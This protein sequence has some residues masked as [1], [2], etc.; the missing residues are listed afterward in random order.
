MTE[1]LNND[2]I[3]IP[4]T[5]DYGFKVTF[6]NESNTVFLKRA[7]QAL[8]NSPIPIKSITFDKTIFEGG[9]REGRSGIYDIACTDEAN[10]HFIV[11]MQV[12]D[13]KFFF[14]RMKFYGWQK[15]NTMVKKGD[16]DYSN[17]NRI[18]SI[19]ILAN[20]ITHHPKYHNISWIKN[21]DNELVDDQTV[22]V[23]VELRKFNKLAKDCKTDLEK[24]IYTM[25]TLHDVKEPIQFP[26]FFTEEWL[27]VAIKELD[28]RNM[29]PDQRMAYEITMSNNAIAMWQE[30]E[31]T[32]KAV[33]QAV[34]QAVKQ[35]SIEQDLKT[36]KEAVIKALLLGLDSDLIAQL[37]DVTIEFIKEVKAEIN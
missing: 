27:K 29:S 5:S 2:Q 30:K 32:D 8:I 20:N 21:Q 17:M 22:Y 1:L 3:F 19:G 24:L 7:L 16:F 33:T 28:S 34:T 15:F 6:G 12:S 18:Y 36:K 31:R 23:T 37:N 9:T 13:F 14:Q 26:P 4:F 10:N 11:E 25:K 35:T